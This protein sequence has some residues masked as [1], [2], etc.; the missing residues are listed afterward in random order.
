MIKEIKLQNKKIRYT[1]K[2]SIRAKRVRFSIYSDCSLVVTKPIFFSENIIEKFIRKKANW[3]LRKLEYFKNNKRP[4]FKNDYENYL[5]HKGESLS[6]VY[7]RINYLNKEYNFKFNKVNIKN[8]KTRWGSCSNKGNLNFNY[9]ILFLPD[10]I[11]DYIIVHELCHLKELNHSPRF[12][13]LVSKSLPNYIGARK[14]L[15]L[16]KGFNIKNK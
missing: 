1:V 12:W 15:S 2:T 3:I 5:K 11:A 10:Y 9:K 6:F 13:N 8:Q 16:W 4:I 7:K 14:D